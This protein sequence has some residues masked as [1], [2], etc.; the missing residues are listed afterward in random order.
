MTEVIIDTNFLIT[1]IKQRIYFDEEI[2]SLI[3]GAEIVMISPVIKEL[4]KISLDKEKNYRLEDREKA[5]LALQLVNGY[6]V[7]R[8]KGKYADKAIIDYV[9]RDSNKEKEILVATIDQELERKL[10]VLRLR[11]MKIKGLKR[12]VMG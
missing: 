11:T 7:V 3:P 2:R 6:R 4:E 1:C 5:G 8:I 9:G 12:I 10:R